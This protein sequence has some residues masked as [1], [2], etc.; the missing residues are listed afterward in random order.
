MYSCTDTFFKMLVSY[1]STF[2]FLF[3]KTVMLIMDMKLAL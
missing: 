2:V 3:I 1:A